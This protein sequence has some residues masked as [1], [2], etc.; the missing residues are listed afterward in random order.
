M[1]KKS[2]R[3]GIKPAWIAPGLVVALLAAACGGGG[4][5]GNGS[6][7]TAPVTENGEAASVA[8]QI[9]NGE[10]SEEEEEE[11][12]S[13]SDYIGFDFDDPDASAAFAAD[14]ERQVQESIVSCMAQEGFE[15]IPVATPGLGANFAFNEEE[16][17]RE[18]GF[19][20][21][22][23]YGQEQ[24]VLTEEENFVDPNLEITESLSES[25]LEAYKQVLH[26]GFDEGSLGSENGEVN[27]VDSF[28]GRGCWGQAFDEVY[29]AQF[30]VFEELAPQFEDLTQRVEADPRYLEANEDWSECMADRG[31]TYS[32]QDAMY[33]EIFDYFQGQL[34]EITGDGGFVDPFVGMSEEEIETLTVEEMENLFDQASQE[35]RADIDQDALEALQQEEI[36]LAVA[37]F[38]CGE[39]LDDLLQE[40]YREYEAD[41]VRD[42]RD[43]LEQLRS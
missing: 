32:S 12:D 30:R 36:D 24:D 41:F 6:T 22:T 23:W 31:H 21:T 9:D 28:T 39:D 40:L 10:G 14:L 1:T 19:G 13:L 43:V 33:E 2:A 5:E 37:A 8:N 38:E 27:I 25:E 4:D 7:D 3:F 17:A 16:F 26:G 18:S 34:D 29:G 20:I 11:P 15:Y 42:N 35:A